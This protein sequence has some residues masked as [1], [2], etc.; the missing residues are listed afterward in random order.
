MKISTF[1]A[2]MESCILR[3]KIYDSTV[4]SVYYRIYYE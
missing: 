4:V 3:R 1:S 2:T